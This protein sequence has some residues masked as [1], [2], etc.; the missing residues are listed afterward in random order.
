M[1]DWYNPSLHRP[2]CW[3]AILITV[4]LAGCRS[5]PHRDLYEDQMASEIRVL[6]D[7]LYEADY[8]NKVLR[9]RLSR[10]EAK[11]S[12]SSKQHPSA[13]PQSDWGIADVLPKTRKKSS[14]SDESAED[15]G[16]TL[17][18]P[19]GGLPDQTDRDEINDRRIETPGRRNEEMPG[20]SSGLEPPSLDS[21]DF[22]DVDLGEPIPPP[23]PDA[24]PE[25]PMGQI[26]LPSLNPPELPEP[27]ALS[28]NP[29]FSG[30]HN[31]DSDPEVDGV[32]LVIQFV[33]DDG[34]VLDLS[35]MDI[36]A[37]LS[38]VLLDSEAEGDDQ[39]AQ[40]GRWEFSAEEVAAMRRSSVQDGIHVAIRWDE[41][42]PSGDQIAA[43]V[44]LA[45]GDV[46][47]EGESRLSLVGKGQIAGWAP[48]GK[49]ATKK[50]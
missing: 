2:A 32:Y 43:F 22:P 47:L 12:H 18:T 29:V 13:D 4:L 39:A 37:D 6:E 16:A 19:P 3:T 17:L 9:N 26:P 38:V 7:Q 35:D 21:L 1:L 41:K 46:K 11:S 25:P 49:E 48:R 40:I 24:P 15:L 28:I 42:H 33:D 50:K 30:G 34:K 36:D 14:R 44:R 10:S 8:E 31:F 20:P 27:V 23:G 5:D 45:N